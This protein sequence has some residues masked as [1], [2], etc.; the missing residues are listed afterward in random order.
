MY[1]YCIFECGRFYRFLGWRGFHLESVSKYPVVIPNVFVGVLFV[2]IFS[3]KIDFS[4]IGVRELCE[5]SVLSR[6]CSLRGYG[7]ISAETGA[8][9]ELFGAAGLLRCV[10]NGYT[11]SDF[12]E[13]EIVPTRRFET[14]APVSDPQPCAMLEKRRGFRAAGL[15]AGP[16][17]R[18]NQRRRTYLLFGSQESPKC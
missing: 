18:E 1:L 6:N 12:G 11:K 5:S 9:L 13:T 16:F 10:S 14:G 4:L 2:V 7:E 15:L 8:S 3:K 17:R